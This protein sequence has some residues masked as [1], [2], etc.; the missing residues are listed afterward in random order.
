[1]HDWM[2]ARFRSQ[3]QPQIDATGGASQP[4]SNTPNPENSASAI[5]NQ[6]IGFR[7]KAIGVIN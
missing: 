4:K 1:M 5:G 2:S 3:N 6:T 7:I